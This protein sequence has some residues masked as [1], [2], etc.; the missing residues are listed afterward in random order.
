MFWVNNE[1]IE[2]D[3]SFIKMSSKKIAELANNTLVWVKE[4]R[5]TKR[6]SYIENV[7]QEIMNGWWHRFRNKPIPTDEEVLARIEENPWNSFNLIPIHGGKAEAAAIRLLKACEYADEIYI[8][9][10]DLRRIS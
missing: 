6:K 4:V 1:T 3:G 7:R 2:C 9:T 8:S 5:E 10:E